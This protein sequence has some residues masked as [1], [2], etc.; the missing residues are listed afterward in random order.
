M[1]GKYNVICKIRAKDT[2]HAKDVIM[3]IEKIAG[4]QRLESMISLE[5]SINDKKRLMKSIFTELTP[6]SRVNTNNGE[7]RST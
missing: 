3:E 2:K 1:T 6:K 4:I 7:D 5:E